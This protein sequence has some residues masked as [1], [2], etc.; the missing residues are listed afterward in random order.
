M[1]RIE[2]IE[3]TMA[4]V[5][6]TRGFRTRARNWFRS[7]R[8]GDYQVINLQRSTWGSGDLYVNLG[9][10]PAAGG[11]AFR[12]AYRCLF[13]VRAEEL[14]VGGVIHRI[15][16]DGATK[17]ELPGTSLLGS[18]IYE[19]TPKDQLMKEVVQVVA[20]P[21]AD[22]MDS[23][24]TFADLAPLINSRPVLK[25]VQLRN[26]MRSLGSPLS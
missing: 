9:W 21:L 26:H 3:A 16:P 15:R 2:A 6:K 23:T 4:A 13:S 22:L 24:T 18:E 14:D 5:F 11:A 7:T 12:P 1:E 19:A 25:S 17:L 20:E 10:D 8:S